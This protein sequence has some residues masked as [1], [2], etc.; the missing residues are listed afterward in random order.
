MDQNQKGFTLIELLIVIVII[1]ILAAGA[2]VALDPASRFRDSRDATRWTDVTGVL[3]A[4]KI[5]EVD[6]RAIVSTLVSDGSNYMVGTDGATAAETCADATV[7]AADTVDLTELVT[8]GAIAQIP[9]APEAAGG[10]TWD[11]GE[12]GY[13]VSYDGNA[14]TVGA[15]DSE[16]ENVTDISV[17][18]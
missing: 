17:T 5:N 12:T 11:A 15:C 10:T 18:R 13:Y 16:G 7:V 3:E 8:E 14:V 4:I 9:V 2:F 6:E 1:V